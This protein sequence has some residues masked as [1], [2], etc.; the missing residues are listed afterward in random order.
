MPRRQRVGRG[1]D[2]GGCEGKGEGE[3]K[4]EGHS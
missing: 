1:A 3:D 2:K 4:G